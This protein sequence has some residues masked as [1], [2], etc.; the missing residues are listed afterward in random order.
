MSDRTVRF[1]ALVG[2]SVCL[3]L[4][5]GLARAQDLTKPLLLVATPQL[6]GPYGQTV[7]IALPA[8]NARH[9]GFIINRVSQNTLA[10]LFP[11]HPP[12]KQ[13]RDP[14]YF[15]G[16]MGLGAIFAFVR[17]QSGRVQ[18]AEKL[19]EDLFVAVNAAA[20][21]RIIEQTPNDAR[22]ISGYVAWAPDELQAELDRGFWILEEPHA[23]LL[24][25][26][27]VGELWHDFIKR[28]RPEQLNPRQINPHHR[29]GGFTRTSW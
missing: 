25:R 21:D 15:G 26:K 4:L 5:A 22:Y 6:K 14:V 23:E 8:G 18:G 27:E 12:S 9:V 3:L 29:G 19:F 1:G 13:V 20:V 11:E 17:S 7:L 24:F 10:S 28:A 16:P 2:L